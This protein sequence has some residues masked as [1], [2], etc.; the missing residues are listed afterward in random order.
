MAVQPMIA[1]IRV[2]DFWPFL[3][4]DHYLDQLRQRSGHVGGKVV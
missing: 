1:K 3:N 2:T 4:K